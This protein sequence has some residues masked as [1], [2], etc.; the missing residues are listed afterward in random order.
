MCASGREGQEGSCRKLGW[1]AGLCGLRHVPYCEGKGALAC[2][3]LSYIF[4]I[5]PISY[6]GRY[7]VERVR[8]NRNWV[9]LD[10]GR[11]RRNIERVRHDVE[12]F[13]FDVEQVMLYRNWIIPNRNRVRSYRERIR[14]D[15][16]RIRLNMNR[17]RLLKNLIMLKGLPLVRY[18][19]TNQFIADLT[20]SFCIQFE[21]KWGSYLNLIL[22]FKFYQPWLTSKKVSIQ[23][24]SHCVIF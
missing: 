2:Y 12:G 6:Q 1:C 22:T 24:N 7:F 16:E 21:Y 10:V 5:V 17:V 9:M 13:R 18:I 3:V 20:V 19:T 14:F 15:R 8:I 4:L 23:W 11:L